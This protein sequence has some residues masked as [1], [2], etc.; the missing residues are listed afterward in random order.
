MRCIL[1]SHQKTRY[2]DVLFGGL[3]LNFGL[4]LM[5]L[6]ET[7]RWSDRVERIRKHLRIAT[8]AGSLRRA[9]RCR[10]VVSSVLRSTVPLERNAS[11]STLTTLS[12]CLDTLCAAV[13]DGSGLG[14]VM[15]FVS[16]IVR[17]EPEVENS[18]AQNPYPP[19][20]LIA[21]Y[22]RTNLCK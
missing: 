13:E 2:Y 6:E 12:R 18:S 22:S 19:T 17:S 10:F 3:T 14:Q 21:Q 20:V 8:M 15:I 16:L 1:A 11:G 4:L 9:V 5:M 7:E